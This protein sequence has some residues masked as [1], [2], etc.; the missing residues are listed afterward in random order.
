MAKK[1]Y[2]KLTDWIEVSTSS[3]GQ[4]DTASPEEIRERQA[5][6]KTQGRKG[7]KLPHYNITFTPANHDYIKTMSK[8]SGI[9]MTAYV[10]KI[11]EK[12]FEEHRGDYEKAKEFLNNI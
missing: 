11:V 7:A 5:A 10:N 6:R 4:Q 3:S 8:V 12:H 1:D 9:S 2:G